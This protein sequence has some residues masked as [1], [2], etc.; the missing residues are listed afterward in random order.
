M[1]FATEGGFGFD[2]LESLIELGFRN[3]LFLLFLSEGA[4]FLSLL[5]CRFEFFFSPREDCGS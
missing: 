5:S 2:G 1:C 3:E 4:S